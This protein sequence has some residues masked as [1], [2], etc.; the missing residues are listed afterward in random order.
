MI[1]GADVQIKELL[2]DI[3]SRVVSCWS[4]ETLCWYK[5]TGSRASFFFSL[6]I[7]DIWK[8]FAKLSLLLDPKVVWYEASASKRYARCRMR[9]EN[10]S[11]PSCAIF[12]LLIT[13]SLID[14]CQERKDR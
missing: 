6:G 9:Y 5:Q 3:G 7:R 4:T 8:L 2:F 14:V 10:I 12:Y 11:D 13:T 1:F